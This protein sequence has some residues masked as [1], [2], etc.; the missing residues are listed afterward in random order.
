MLPWKASALAVVRTIGTIRILKSCLN[1]FSAQRFH[2]ETSAILV[3][4][5]SGLGIANFK[6]FKSHRHIVPPFVPPLCPG[7]GSAAA[8][9]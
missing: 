9:V 7:F 4:E 8:D 6:M 2:E 1:V 5:H 3:G